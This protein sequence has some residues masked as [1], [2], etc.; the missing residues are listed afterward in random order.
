MKWE[1]AGNIFP[2]NRHTPEVRQE[3]PRSACRNTAVP[4]SPVG[5]RWG[6]TLT[7][8]A[9]RRQARGHLLCELFCE[10]GS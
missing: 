8:T 6:S 3:E 5:A 4:V 10:R 2:P 7:G 1:A 9:H